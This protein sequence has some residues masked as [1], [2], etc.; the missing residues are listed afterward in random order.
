MDGC[1]ADLWISAESEPSATAV[2]RLSASSDA[3]SVAVEPACYWEDRQRKAEKIGIACELNSKTAQLRI[4]ASYQ[5]PFGVF[6]HALFWHCS[7]QE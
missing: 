4:T 1:P 2:D 7:G 6:P 5:H 3:S